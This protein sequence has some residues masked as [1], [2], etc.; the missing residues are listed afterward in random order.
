MLIRTLVGYYYKKI[1]TVSACTPTHTHSHPY[2]HI[3][4]CTH[5]RART[6]TR[7]LIGHVTL[8]RANANKHTCTHLAI[9]PTH[10]QTIATQ[11]RDAHKHTRT[12]SQS[13]VT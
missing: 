9:T 5:A 6:R 8:R 7:T 10:K 1:T 4:I 13:M 12:H 3:L 2:T 11:S